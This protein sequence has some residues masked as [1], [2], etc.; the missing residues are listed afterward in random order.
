MVFKYVSYDIFYIQ[1][2]VCKNLSYGIQVT[3]P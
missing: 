1:I 2:M 3:K